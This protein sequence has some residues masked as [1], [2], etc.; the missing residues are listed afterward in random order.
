[1]YIAKT[2]EILKI[3]ICSTFGILLLLMAFSIFEMCNDTAI[4]SYYDYVSVA[5]QLLC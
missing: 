3:L 2:K 5:Q 4:P 1:M